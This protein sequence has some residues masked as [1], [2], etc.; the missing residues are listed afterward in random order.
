MKQEKCLDC[1]W[2]LPVN[3]SH[4]PR[5][6][7]KMA[8]DR[9]GDRRSLEDRREGEEDYG[10]PERRREKRRKAADRRRFAY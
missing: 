10:G 3:V 2:L 7:K 6:G 8:N 1:G 9:S 4:C 5:C